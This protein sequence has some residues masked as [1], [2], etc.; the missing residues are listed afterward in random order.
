M[1]RN[2]R[3]VRIV[4]L[5]RERFNITCTLTDYSVLI[6]NQP[7]LVLQHVYMLDRNM[8][9]TGAGMRQ[10]ISWQVMLSIEG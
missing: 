1:G 10:T 8:R 3:L 6:N 2:S 9:Q 4:E 5:K 7:I